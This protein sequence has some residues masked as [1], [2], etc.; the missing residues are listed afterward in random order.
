[1][2]AI[3]RTGGKQYR[4]QPGDH[5]KVEKLEA[6]IGA[7]IKIQDVLFIGGD[8]PQFGTPVLKGA[9]VEAVVTQQDK[10]KKVLVFHKK[11]RKGYRRM[12]GHRQPFTEIF[13]SAITGPNGQSAKADS[14]PRII[15]PEEI[16]QKKAAYAEASKGKEGKK[17]SGET[18]AAAR[19]APKKAKA[20]KAAPK[21]A[22]SK[23]GAKVAK[24]KAAKKAAKKK[25]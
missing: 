22:A 19:P 12:K 18:K 4:V 20:K 10:D 13:I 6:K 2:F 3:I 8:Q 16:A 1:M 21:K 14:E 7:S 9:N 11:R 5:L 25:E 17:A 23:R 15:N 24:K